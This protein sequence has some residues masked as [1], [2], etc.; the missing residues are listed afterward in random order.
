MPFRS[1]PQEAGVRLR[2]P[3]TPIPGG[4]P[5]RAKDSRG[6]GD[7]GQSMTQLHCRTVFI[8]DMHLGSKGAR[9]A[10][11]SEFLKAVRCD[12][13]YLV[14]DII[15]MW[16]LRQRWYWPAEHNEVIRRILKIAKRGTEVYFIPG[17]HDEAA[18]QFHHHEFGGVRVLPQA[19]HITA[20]GRK[21]L[22][23][24]GDQYDLI[25]RHSRLLSVAGSAAYDWLIGVNRVYNTAR[26]MV[27]LPYWSLS[28]YVKLKVKTACTFMS[29]FEQTLIAEAERRGLD[30]VVCGH[31][32]KAEARAARIGHGS[33]HG[34]PI[35]SPDG[36][37]DGGPDEI[38]YYNC[39]DWVES[40][41]ALIE[42]ED[43]AIELI[44]GLAWL[45]AREGGHGPVE[46]KHAVAPKDHFDDDE[47]E[48]DCAEPVLVGAVRDAFRGAGPHGLPR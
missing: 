19:V 21:L 13:L 11:L 34:S 48:A 30:G 45:A 41:T 2:R 32:H 7:A 39:G 6:G 4:R 5:E 29:R 28:Q 43:G 8:S 1:P 14:G 35:G 44:D 40:C 20:D 10:E 18:R 25:V 46:P 36:S 15:D 9:A 37:R 31:I 33:P 24:H 12:R 16:R 22:I 27:G 26:R 38:E 3:P 17:N 47:L 23:T 42:H